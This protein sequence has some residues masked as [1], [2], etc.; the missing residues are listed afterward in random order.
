M[1]LIESPT[2]AGLG[3]E[4][5]PTFAAL[6]ASLRPLDF[7][8]HAGAVGGHYSGAW[9]SGLATGVGAGGALMSARWSSVDRVLVPL[10]IR[11]SVVVDTPFAAPQEVA[12]DLMRVG[13]FSVADSGGT[14]IT[15]AEAL[16]R[17]LGMRASQLS[18][19]RIATTAALGAGTGTE[20]AYPLGALVLPV[21]NVA[22]AAASGVLYEL[23]EGV[24]HPIVLA[25]STG[26]RIR[27][28]FA[29]GTGGVLRF[30]FEWEWAELPAAF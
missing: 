13:N 1:A 7:K 12:V 29:M 19:F 5:D 16:K 6:R 15:I 3:V 30:T 17:G 9:S 28:R 14:L 26:L 8:S 11:A 20:E 27:N 24:S 2:K 23:T 4:V 21:S 25:G 22:G 10:R 18:E